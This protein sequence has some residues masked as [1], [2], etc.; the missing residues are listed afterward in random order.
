M[1]VVSER[2]ARG[3]VKAVSCFLCPFIT[4]NPLGKVNTVGKW[5]Y[6]VPKSIFWWENWIWRSQTKDLLVKCC[7]FL[8]KLVKFYQI[9][10]NKSPENFYQ[11]SIENFETV[12]NHYPKFKL[13]K[14]LKTN[15]IGSLGKNWHGQ[16]DSSAIFSF[17]W[18]FGNSVTAII[19]GEI[20]RIGDFFSNSFFPISE[21]QTFRKI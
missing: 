17:L 18:F 15:S 14:K 21:T 6:L 2:H 12:R 13:Q 3:G 19:L 10:P 5:H 1:K 7:Y 4:L 16:T 9:L 11:A 20:F 8:V